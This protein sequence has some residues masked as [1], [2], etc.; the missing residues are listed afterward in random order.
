[1]I[2]L[3]KSTLLLIQII[4]FKGLGSVCI[5]NINAISSVGGQLFWIFTIMLARYSL[6]SCSW[7]LL[8]NAS[9]S[10]LSSSILFSQDLF[11]SFPSSSLCCLSCILHHKTTA[12]SI[13]LRIF[14]SF[15]LSQLS[16]R[17][18]LLIKSLIL[19]WFMYNF[20]LFYELLPYY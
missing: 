9:C 20:D 1:M 14:K 11:S 5:K 16:S 19:Q 10:S 3:F 4:S 2:G 15:K 6:I 17:N 18:L 12:A 7:A 8:L 13:Y